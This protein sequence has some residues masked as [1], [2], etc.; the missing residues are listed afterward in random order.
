MLD[1]LEFSSGIML[2]EGIRLWWKLL[3]A[4]LQ[5]AVYDVVLHA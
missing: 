1:L 5:D 2:R 3:P 4:D